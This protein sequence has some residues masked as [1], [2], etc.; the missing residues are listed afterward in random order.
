MIV[1]Y[2]NVVVK[3]G[4]NYCFWLQQLSTVPHDVITL[5]SHGVMCVNNMALASIFIIPA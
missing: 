5:N 3:L 2:F 4:L 1:A